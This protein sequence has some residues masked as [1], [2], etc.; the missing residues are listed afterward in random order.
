MH[1]VSTL[2]TLALAVCLVNGMGSG[3]TV[4]S[5]PPNEPQTATAPSASKYAD[6]SDNGHKSSAKKQK[7]KEGK[8]K[9]QPARSQEERDFD[10]VL[11]GI[12]G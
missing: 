11:L 2:A 4:T 5:Q 12:F 3:Q 7:Q 8:N 10:R 9:P 1:K 6:G